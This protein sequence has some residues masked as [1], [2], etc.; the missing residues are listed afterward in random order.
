MSKEMALVGAPTELGPPLTGG[1]LIFGR[2]AVAGSAVGGVPE[3]QEMLD[4]C[5]RTEGR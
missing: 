5:A 4:F 2:K 1:S 3:T